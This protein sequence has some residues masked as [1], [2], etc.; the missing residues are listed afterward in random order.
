VA[1]PAATAQGTFEDLGLG[2]VLA[3]LFGEAGVAED[4]WHLVSLVRLLGRLPVPASVAS[5]KPG[6][7]PAAL[8]RALIADEAVR[9]YIG[10]NVW[11]D[12]A[13]FNRESYERL[14]WWLL[15]LD[16]LAAVGG[17][18]PPTAR[19]R[20]AVAER[21]ADTDRLIATLIRAGEASG[22][23]LDRLETAA[24]ARA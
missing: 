6:E 5:R 2:P 20:E 19:S 11:D 7:R 4:P 21:L 3:A 14:V 18:V 13:W 17:P 16:A 8:V 1:D 15:L 9:P 22:Y 23:Q 10:V 24:S 12:V